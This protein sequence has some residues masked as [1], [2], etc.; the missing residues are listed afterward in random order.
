MLLEIYSIRDSKS[1]VFTQPFF[2]LT[3]GE[4]ER[5]FQ[6]LVNDPKSTQ[7]SY[8]EDFALFKLAKYD[9][10]TGKITPLDQ[11]QHICNAVQLK[12]NVQ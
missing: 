2:Q 4:A 1:E 5:N 11:P 10:Q 8:P 3:A 12:R 9:D 6:T 7:Y